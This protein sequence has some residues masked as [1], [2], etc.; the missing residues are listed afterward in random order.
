MREFD[1]GVRLG[2]LAVALVTLGASLGMR[3]PGGRGAAA[4]ARTSSRTVR[5]A[6]GRHRVA[7]RGRPGSELQGRVDAAGAV[8]G[9]DV[10]SAVTAALRLGP[11]GSSDGPFGGTAVVGERDAGGDAALLVDLWRRCVGAAGHGPG[12]GV[13]QP[14]R[15]A[16]RDA[17]PE[18]RG[19]GHAAGAG[20]LAG[21]P[22]PPERLAPGGLAA[23]R[24]ARHRDARAGARSRGMVGRSAA[25]ALPDRCEERHPSGRLTRISVEP[26]AGTGTQPRRWSA[27][28]GAGG[29]RAPLAAR[30]GPDLPLARHGDTAVLDRDPPST[31]PRRTWARRAALGRPR[32]ATT[33]PP[34]TRSATRPRCRRPH[35]R[36]R[37]HAPRTSSVTPGRC[38]S[39]HTAR[40]SAG[41]RCAGARRTTGTAASTWSG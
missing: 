7:R 8:T 29:A 14:P 4:R 3:R 17:A 31:R 15:P 40:T 2:R 16:D 21:G 22:G 37:S 26:D 9:Y 38:A 30:R 27:A 32:S 39:G 34:R 12:A 1:H 24:G 28:A 18:P 11:A 25:G 41:A 35:A 5:P 10:G 20:H 33:R 36:R 19:A 23:H 13:R 6:A